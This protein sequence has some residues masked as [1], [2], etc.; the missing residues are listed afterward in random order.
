MTAPLFPVS[1]AFSFFL[2]HGRHDAT[3]GQIVFE[4]PLGTPG[5]NTLY[6]VGNAASKLTRE[7]WAGAR[8]LM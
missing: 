5:G 4:A 8:D 7:V 6:T 2:G 3:F 1:P